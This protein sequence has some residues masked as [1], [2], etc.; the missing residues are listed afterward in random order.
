MFSERRLVD[1]LD[2]RTG[3]SGDISTFLLLS[4]IDCNFTKAYVSLNY[5]M[6]KAVMSKAV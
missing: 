6:Y 4:S 2:F 5:I 3:Y 1:K